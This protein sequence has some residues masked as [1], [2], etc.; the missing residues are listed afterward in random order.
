MV[1]LIDQR[2]DPEVKVPNPKVELSYT[3]LVV[4]YV[5]HCPSLMTV[6]HALEDSVPFLQKLE[7]LI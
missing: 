1:M 4:W 6:V 5:M 3:Y 2:D 7:H